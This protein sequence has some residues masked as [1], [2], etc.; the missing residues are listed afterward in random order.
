MS[1]PRA[2]P[3]LESELCPGKGVKGK[4]RLWGTAL[5]QKLC[6]FASH[7]LLG[8]QRGAFLC[9]GLVGGLLGLWGLFSVKRLN[10]L[11][12]RRLGG[13]VLFRHPLWL[14]L[15]YLCSEGLDIVCYFGFSRPSNHLLER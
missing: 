2:R 1:P 8:G 6:S 14:E 11:G 5:P 15:P 10:E 3:A 4:L 9:F 7:L 13:L 12:G